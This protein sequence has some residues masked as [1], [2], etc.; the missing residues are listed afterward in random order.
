MGKKPTY[1]ELEQRIKGLEAK[2]LEG[3][4]AE[5]E[6]QHKINE[7][8]TFYRTTLGREERIVELKQEVNEL[9]EQLGKNNKYRD[10]SKE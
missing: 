10:Y 5:R 2:A 6:L 1:E 8:E 7:L 4:Q 9:L 3:R